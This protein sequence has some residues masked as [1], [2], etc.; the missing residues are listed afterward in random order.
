MGRD[1]RADLQTQPA[2]DFVAVVR[3]TLETRGTALNHAVLGDQA[4]WGLHQENT[5]RVLDALYHQAETSWVDRTTDPDDPEVKRARA[6]AQRS[7]RKPPPHPPIRP[8]AL[9]P[10]SV[11]AQVMGHFVEQQTPPPEPPR[12]R[13]VSTAEFDAVITR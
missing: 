3:Q 9:R 13:A 5:A 4:E 10:A 11:A 1:L 7:G 6:E 12:Q 2:R 8:V